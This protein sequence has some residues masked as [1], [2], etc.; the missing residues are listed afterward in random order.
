[1][2]ATAVLAALLVLKS[3]LLE[4]GTLVVLQHQPGD[5]RRPWTWRMVIDHL[6]MIRAAG[7]TAVLLSPHESACGGA[8]SLGY[9]P[10]D[11]RSFQSAH[12]TEAD[13]AEL[14]GKA[15]RLRIQV[16]A[17]VVLNHMCS[18]NFTYPRFSRRDFH[19]FGAIRDPNDQWQVENGALSGLEDL[20][21]D[22]PYVRGELWN[23][24]VKTNNMGFDGFRWD[25][26]KH[27]P[28]WYWR[29]H[30]LANVR[31]WGKYS[32]GEVLNGDVG[33]LS[34]YVAA[35]MAVT[36]YA[37]YFAMRDS[38]RFGGNL[39]ALDGAGLAAADGPGALT[40]V[41]NH[42]VGPPANRRLAYAFIAAY[43]GYPAFFD[44]D[45]TDPALSNLAWVQ[46]TLAA[47]PYVNRFKDADTI[48]FTRGDRLLAG[49]N[50]GGSWVSRSVQTPWVDTPI[51]DY[52]G[53]VADAHTDQAGR[54]EIWI[55]PTGY[56]MM[57]PP[58]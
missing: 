28:L 27:V 31:R 13:L 2:R 58:R 53:H 35:G 8:R 12:G 54:V 33:Y 10:F 32:F 19:T 36:D 34:S 15:H 57:A 52:S 38:F 11:F 14:I 3:A 48:V 17:D 55:P 4:A 42:D 26:A 24:I 23:F 44:V 25:A 21:Q 20:D 51:H 22:S 40:F 30:V 39:A 29:D 6:P 37:L 18:H 5:A 7:Y 1:V 16:Y 41:E 56:V 46:N 9:D 47:G 43:P 50:Q 45:L 49:I